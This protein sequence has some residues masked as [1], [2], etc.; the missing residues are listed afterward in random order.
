MKAYR[1]LKLLEAES[2][3]SDEVYRFLDTFAEMMENENSYIRS[4]GQD[5][6]L[7]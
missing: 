1:N 3:K 5:G 7:V 6:I 2:E 4:R